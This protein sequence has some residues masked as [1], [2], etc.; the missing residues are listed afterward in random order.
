M[1]YNVFTVGYFERDNQT[2]HDMVASETR[3]LY[4]I[5]TWSRWFDTFMQHLNSIYT[6]RYLHKNFNH[7]SSQQ[8]RILKICTHYATNIN[9]TKYL[10]DKLKH[11]EESF[12][13]KRCG[14][15]IQYLFA[16]KTNST[17][18]SM[19]RIRSTETLWQMTY[20]IEHSY[21]THSKT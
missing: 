15:K 20:Q 16:V 12:Q 4:D 8:R 9:G 1:L 21:P 7:Y 14:H 3:A 13:S 5:A 17:K 11:L 2:N 10:S 19:T 6:D 18:I